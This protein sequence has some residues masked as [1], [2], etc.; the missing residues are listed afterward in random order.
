MSHLWSTS[1]VSGSGEDFRQIHVKVMCARMCKKVAPSE[2][3]V[4]VK[5]VVQLLLR[6]CK[7]TKV[8]LCHYYRKT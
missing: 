4:V 8:S 2:T 3:A 5:V 6:D 1:L 7:I